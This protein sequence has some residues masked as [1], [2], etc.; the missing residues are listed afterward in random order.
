MRVLS[1]AL[2]RNVGLLFLVFF[3]FGAR[4]EVSPVQTVTF[5]TALFGVA[6]H[7]LV[8]FRALEAGRGRSRLSVVV[9]NERDEVV[10]RGSQV[11]EAGRPATFKFAQEEIVPDGL[12]SAVHATLVLTPEGDD[13]HSRVFLNMEFFNMNTLVARG[14]PACAPPARG[15]GAEFLCDGGFNASNEIAIGLH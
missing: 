4:A 9:K 1:A 6:P 7:E 8:I 10:A 12:F 15:A 13:A 5:R 11:F 14:G 3:A 2:T